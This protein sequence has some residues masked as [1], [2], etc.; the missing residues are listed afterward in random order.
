M[1]NHSIIMPYNHHVFRKIKSDRGL[2]P[3]EIKMLMAKEIRFQTIRN[4]IS[5][6][7]SNLITKGHQI[8]IQI[9]MRSRNT[10]QPLVCIL[11]LLILR[12]TD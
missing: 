6:N 8:A 4:I 12:K 3:Q 5:S 9:K 2:V 11:L 10:N 1:Q 7:N